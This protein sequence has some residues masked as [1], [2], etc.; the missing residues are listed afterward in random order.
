MRVDDDIE[1]IAAPIAGIDDRLARLVSEQADIR[2]DFLAVV[3]APV[4][5]DFEIKLVLV[6]TVMDR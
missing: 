5:R 6:V 3:I 4:D 1:R 2:P